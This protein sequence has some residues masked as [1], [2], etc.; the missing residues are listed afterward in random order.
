MLMRKL[1]VLSL[2]I[3]CFPALASAQVSYTTSGST[4]TQ[5][6]NTLIQTGTNQTWTNN[7][8]LTGWWLY[9]QPAPGT[10]IT[11]YNAGTGSSNT[12]NFYSFGAST[13]D[14][15]RALGGVASGG[16]YFGTPGPVSGAVAGWIAVSLTN[17]TGESLT[18][19]TVNYNGEQWRDGGTATGGT[20]VAQTMVME[21]GFGATFTTVATWTPAGASFNF[22]SPVFTN[23]TTGGAA[24]NGNVAGLVAGLGGTI[25]DTWNNGDTLWIRFIENNDVG[26]DHGLSLDNFSFSGVSAAV[27]EPTTYALVGVT[28]AT[29]GFVTYRRRRQLK[30]RMS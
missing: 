6:F 30:L 8:T 2:T 3:L 5:D 1:L 12:G 13:T 9:R 19:L 7:S 10:D 25:N 18:S 15:D 27:P 26:N 28:M 29:A 21:Y 22:T 23:A 16:A 17:N 11:T 14:A 24:V 20:N 4:Y